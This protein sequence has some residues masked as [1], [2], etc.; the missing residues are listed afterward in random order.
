MSLVAVFEA[1]SNLGLSG[2][3]ASNRNRGKPNL[4]EKL[5]SMNREIKWTKR[6]GEELRKFD[7][8]ETQKV[9]KSK[10]RRVR[11]RENIEWRGNG[12]FQRKHF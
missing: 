11:L 4:K 10:R 3:R 7:N 5:E 12:S 9:I 6:K 8:F 2:F 1:I